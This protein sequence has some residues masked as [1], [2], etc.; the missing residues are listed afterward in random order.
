[1]NMI[2]ENR[3]K[4]KRE[5][6]TSAV[7]SIFEKIKHEEIRKRIRIGPSDFIPHLRDTKI[8]YIN[9]NGNQFGNIPYELELKLKVEDSPN[10]AGIMIDII[11]LIQ[12]ARDR[13]LGGNIAEISA[14][15]FKHPLINYKEEEISSEIKKFLKTNEKKK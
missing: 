13:G 4:N 1:M 14:Y 3:L 10:S 5:S 2:D 12:I 15:G 9:I 8:C 6:K 7:V 11:R